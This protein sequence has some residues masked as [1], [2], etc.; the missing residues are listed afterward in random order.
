ML[1]GGVWDL[2]HSYR[3]AF[4]AAALGCLLAMLLAMAVRPPEEPRLDIN[5]NQERD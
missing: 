5:R 3:W 4:I 2:L 1:A